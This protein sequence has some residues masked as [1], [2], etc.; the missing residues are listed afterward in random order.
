MS[1]C[2]CAVPAAWRSAHLVRM[3]V[4]VGSCGLWDVKTSP[5]VCGGS[6]AGYTRT[7]PSMVTT[8]SRTTICM[9]SGC[10][11]QPSPHISIVRGFSLRVTWV[12]H[13]DMRA[14]MWRATLGA[15]SSTVHV[16]T[17]HVRSGARSGRVAVARPLVCKGRRE[18]SIV[19]ARAGAA[20][21]ISELS[22]QVHSSPPPP[23]HNVPHRPRPLAA[24]AS[25]SLTL[26]R[27]CATW[28]EGSR[29]H[30]MRTRGR[31]TPGTSPHSICAA[32]H[33][34][35]RWRSPHTQGRRGAARGRGCCRQPLSSGQS[36]V[37]RGR[38]PHGA[39]AI[40][41]ESLILQGSVAW[42]CT[43]SRV[44]FMGCLLSFSLSYAELREACSSVTT[45]PCHTAGEPRSQ[46]VLWRYM[47]SPVRPREGL[48][49]VRLSYPELSLQRMQT[50][51]TRFPYNWRAL[52]TRSVVGALEVQVASGFTG[53]LLHFV[54]L[55]YGGTGSQRGVWLCTILRPHAATVHHSRTYSGYF[56]KSS[57][58][59]L[60]SRARTTRPTPQQQT[61]QP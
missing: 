37:R 2:A 34:V 41:R 54:S 52:F 46:G 56:A 32:Q 35:S 58:I 1:Q 51:K 13:G 60:V 25:W 20:E 55:P 26:S 44:R 10:R 61:K 42:S 16:R 5:P 11:V 29:I 3:R 49:S 19:V 6:K 38:A 40:Q 45:R 9:H 12:E 43:S 48:L 18:S 33:A 23:N 17:T 57:Q 7:N 4:A 47:S 53:C 28:L 15:A 14:A 31:R 59:T 36:C 39:V 24:C 8:Y 22:E 30:Q 21:S 50:L 27:V